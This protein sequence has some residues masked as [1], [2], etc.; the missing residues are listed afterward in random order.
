MLTAM[1]TVENLYGESFDTWDLNV[2]AEYHEQRVGTK[3]GVRHPKTA[4][5]RAERTASRMGPAEQAID[6]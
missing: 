2:E 3:P 6:V 5:P 1:L 4:R